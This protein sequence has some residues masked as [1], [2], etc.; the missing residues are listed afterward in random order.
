[1]DYTIASLEDAQGTM[2]LDFGKSGNKYKVSIHNK[3]TKDYVHR[4]FAEMDKA[5]EVFEK[6][7]K[8]VIFGNYSYEDRKEL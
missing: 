8:H 2:S 3:E 7:S 5:Y 6:I 1:M 4:L